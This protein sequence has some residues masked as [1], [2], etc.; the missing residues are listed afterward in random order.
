MG[1]VGQKTMPHNYRA[2]GSCIGTNPL[3]KDTDGDGI[4]DGWNKNPPWRLV[5]LVSCLRSLRFF[6]SRRREGEEFD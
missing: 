4:I 6:L 1:V 3:S 5:L 2:Y